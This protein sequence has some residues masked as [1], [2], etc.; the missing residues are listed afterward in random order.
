MGQ[1]WELALELLRSGESEV[2]FRGVSLWRSTGGPRADGRIRVS[3]LTR[4]G[5]DAPCE[6]RAQEIDRGRQAIAEL[7]ASDGRLEALF[8]EFGTTWSYVSDDGHGRVLLE[9]I[10]G[11]DQRATD[12]TLILHGDCPRTPAPQ[13]RSACRVWISRCRWP[14]RR[15]AGPDW[16][17]RSW[18]TWQRRWCSSRGSWLQGWWSVS[19]TRSR[20]WS[21]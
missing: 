18:S 11:P 1:R 2:L 3:V 4:T 19:S 17:R 10:S 13:P 7:L 14:A 8:D 16:P 15:R 20:A 9:D 6:R 21:T 12:R 5:P